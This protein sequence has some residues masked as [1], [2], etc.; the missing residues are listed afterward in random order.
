MNHFRIISL[1]SQMRE[2][3]SDERSGSFLRG[4]A[5][6]THIDTRHAVM[7]ILCT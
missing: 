4:I 6:Q 2:R 7:F 5:A 1:S 3:I